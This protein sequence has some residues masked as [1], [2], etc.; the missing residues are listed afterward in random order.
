MPTV[1][2]TENVQKAD[3]RYAI[4]AF[5][6]NNMEIIQ[7]SPRRAGNRIPYDFEGLRGGSQICQAC[8]PYE[9]DWAAVEDT[10]LPIAVFVTTGGL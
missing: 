5:N 3:K 7:G 4:G 9:A 6:V 8:L 2:S 10:N 1:T